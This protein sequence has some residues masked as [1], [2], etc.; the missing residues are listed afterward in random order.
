MALSTGSLADG[1]L[2]STKAALY[3]V[4]TGKVAHV[5]V[6]LVNAGASTRTVNLYVKRSGGTS[7]RVAA[8][9]KSL[10]AGSD[11]VIFPVSGQALVGLK[12]SAGD[13]LEG[14]ASAAAEVDYVVFGATENAV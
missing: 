11:P 4:A 6:S 12:L 7:R 3:T 13:A 8:K 10:A 2:P 9:D 5:W 14:D 1:Q